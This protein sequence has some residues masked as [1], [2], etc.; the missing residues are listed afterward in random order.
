[1]T[2]ITS[3]LKANIFIDNVLS[4][5]DLNNVIFNLPNRKYLNDF[6]NQELN[7]LI[8]LYN[9]K[10]ITTNDIYNSLDELKFKINN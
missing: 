7:S 9:T 1:M 6:C 2:T 3:I 10:E 8:A 4:A 5:K